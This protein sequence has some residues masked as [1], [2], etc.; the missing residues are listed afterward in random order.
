MWIEVLILTPLWELLWD[1]IW[2]LFILQTCWLILVSIHQKRS[3]NSFL[4]ISPL[5]VPNEIL[6]IFETSKI[7]KIFWFCCINALIEI[8]K[9]IRGKF[10]EFHVLEIRKICSDEIFF[11]FAFVIFMSNR[12]YTMSQY[13]NSNFYLF[14]NLIYHTLECSKGVK[15]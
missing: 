13:F 10:H 4:T 6:R 2:I 14:S 3:K 5:T 12:N 11:K 1:L 15:K 8:K 7:K 9:V